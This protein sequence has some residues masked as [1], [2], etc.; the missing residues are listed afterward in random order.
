MNPGK[1]NHRI[2]FMQETV[3]FDD[4]GGQT[5]TYTPVVCSQTD[6]TDVTWGDLQPIKQWN[7][8]AL[9]AGASVLDG[10]R[11]LVIRWRSSFYPTKSMLFEDLNNPGDIYTVHSILPYYPGSK[12][13][14]QNTDAAVYKDQVFVFILGKKRL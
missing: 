8:L 10:D 13:T 2:R 12:S 14:F 9:E 6:P 11:T 7:Q 1:L 5:V 3:S 4:A